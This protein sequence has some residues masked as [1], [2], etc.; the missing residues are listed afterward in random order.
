MRRGLEARTGE[1][2]LPLDVADSL[3]AEWRRVAQQI[4]FNHVPDD[5]GPAEPDDAGD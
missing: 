2:T 5:E 1:Q 3:D 4:D